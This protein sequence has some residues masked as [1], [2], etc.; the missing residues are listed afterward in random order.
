MMLYFDLRIRTEG[1][2]LAIQAAA[3]E[4]GPADPTLVLSQ[5]IP[6]N[7]TNLVTMR[8]MLYFAGI[9]AAFLALYLLL[10]GI[11]MA[12]AF[13]VAGLNGVR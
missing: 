9:S 12:M 13:G 3:G 5:N 4:G 8:E 1:L 11:V 10:V 6:P 7:A 2:D